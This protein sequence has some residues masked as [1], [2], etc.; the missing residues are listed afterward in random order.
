MF[1]EF[2]INAG[3]VEELHTLWLQ[4]PQ[5]VTAY[6]REFFEGNG[7]GDSVARAAPPAATP[8]LPSPAPPTNRSGAAHATGVN[9]VTNGKRNGSAAHA[10]SDGESAQS[11]VRLSTETMLES[12]GAPGR[13]APLITSQPR[14]G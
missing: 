3:Y 6:W 5:S 4:A 14:S 11:T 2:G 9:G 12:G 7:A 1:D 8:A 10:L 13:A